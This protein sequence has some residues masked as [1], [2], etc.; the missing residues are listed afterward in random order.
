MNHDRLIADYCRLHS[1]LPL[2]ELE[3]LERETHL[4]TLSPQMMSGALQGQLLFLLCSLQQPLAA[5]EIGTFTGY[6]TLCLAKGLP[7]NGRLHTIEINPELSHI[8]RKYFEKT[9]L[10]PK[11]IAHTGDARLI[12]PTL[13]DKFDLVFIDAAKFDYDFYYELVFDRVN[14]GGL[15]LADN[16]LWGGKIVAQSKDADTLAMAAFND[17]VQ[18]DPRVENLMLPLRDGLLIARKL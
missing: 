18:R 17:K 12:I 14:P 7:E 15:I 8:N 16:V 1:S 13:A 10:A 11:I 4:H 3:E 2:Q 9:G 6:G 5:L